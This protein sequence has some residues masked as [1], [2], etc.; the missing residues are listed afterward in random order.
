MFNNPNVDENDE[1]LLNVAFDEDESSTPLKRASQPIDGC[2]AKKPKLDDSW[3]SE[4]SPS[5][6]IQQ[7]SNHTKC[8]TPNTAKRLFPGPAGLFADED[9]SIA[10][11]QLEICSQKSS[12]IFKGGP[13]EEMSKDFKISNSSHLYDRFNIAW[14]KREANAN[15]F[16][17]HKAPFLAG[18]LVSLEVTKDQKHKSVNVTLK[19]FSGTIQ[20][21]IVY[22]LYEQHANFLILGSVLVLAKFGV[23]SC[24]C[25]KCDN[26]HLTINSKNLSAVYKQGEKT[27]INEIVPQ[28][29]LTEYESRKKEIAIINV[30]NRNIL[31]C[32]SYNDVCKRPFN[33]TFIAKTCQKSANSP[34]SND[35]NSVLLDNRHKPLFTFKKN[36]T[37]VQNSGISDFLLEDKQKPE[38][39]DNQINREEMVTGTKKFTFKKT[40][41]KAVN[42]NCNLVNGENNFLSCLKPKEDVNLT[43]END[44]IEQEQIWKEALEDVDLNSLF[45]DDFG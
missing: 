16:A 40:S 11:S 31:K 26:H 2:V 39:S 41:N 24:S 13:W 37:T 42:N 28:E 35:N 38:I 14:I 30:R 45:S 34:I 19:D 8:Y 21:N 32:N 7:K 10:S 1:I 4:S 3:D 9:P 20:G 43:I 44:S 15:A 25:E 17:V 29:V 18:V 5:I 23:L 12:T 36:P 27:V 33:N 22:S 6:V